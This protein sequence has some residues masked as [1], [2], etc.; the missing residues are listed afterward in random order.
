MEQKSIGRKEVLGD[1]E[2]YGHYWICQT[3]EVR[4]LKQERRSSSPGVRDYEAWALDWD[5]FTRLGWRGWNEMQRSSRE[6]QMSKMSEMNVVEAEKMW[7]EPP[8]HR[9]GKSLGTSGVGGGYHQLCATE[10]E[11]QSINPQRRAKFHLVWGV[12]IF[13]SK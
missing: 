7:F 3:M 10:R 8:N 6:E 13:L 1:K 5:C 9:T 11:L 4:L 12:T 2:F